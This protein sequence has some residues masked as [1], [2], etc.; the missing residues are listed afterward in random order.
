MKIS[1]LNFAGANPF[2]DLEDNIFESTRTVLAGAANVS[3]NTGREA[4]I[5]ST[6]ILYGHAYSFLEHR[7]VEGSKLRFLVTF[8][9]RLWLV[10]VSDSLLT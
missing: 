3:P 5:G 10:F 1:D 9:L 7:I 8:A 2:K 6:G 4:E